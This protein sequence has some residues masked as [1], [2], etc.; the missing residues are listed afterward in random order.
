VAATAT[1]TLLVTDGEHGP[2]VT[3]FGAVRTAIADAVALLRSGGESGTGEESGTDEERGNSAPRRVAITVGEAPPDALEGTDA[4]AEAIDLL[5]RTEPGQLL[6]SPTARG[7]LGAHRYRLEARPDG[8]ALVEWR[9]DR[10]D[11]ALPAFLATGRTL[12]GRDGNLAQA[13]QVVERGRGPR[14]I[15]LRGEPG[16][17]KTALAGV[18]AGLARDRGYAV[19]AGRCTE[20][21][22]VPYQPVVDACRHLVDAMSVEMLEER[23]GPSARLLPIV[24]PRL[25]I[26]PEATSPDARGLLHR[27]LGDL[28]VDLLGRQP[29]LLVVDDVQWAR[30]R[31]IELLADAW[32]AATDGGSDGDR[33][34]L[35]TQRTGDAADTTAEAIERLADDV[36]AE[37]VD[38][39]ALG[40]DDIA[41]LIALHDADL[42]GNADTVREIQVRSGGNPFFAEELTFHFRDATGSAPVPD[43]LREVVLQRVEDLAPSATS[44]LSM[45]A[46]VGARFSPA[47][48]AAATGEPIE[49]VTD[50][51]DAAVRR[52]LLVADADQ[53]DFKHALARDALYV[54]MTRAR[55]RRLHQRLAAALG[56]TN[57]ELV[58]I[59]RALGATVDT[60]DAVGT[61]A[62]AVAEATQPMWV[63]DMRPLLGRSLSALDLDPHPRHDRA[64]LFLQFAHFA[65]FAGDMADAAKYCEQ[66]AYEAR[67]VGDVGLF[68]LSVK[69]WGLAWPDDVSERVVPLAEEALRDA[70]DNDAAVADACVFLATHYSWLGNDVRRAAELCE[71]AYDAAV[72]LDED[73]RRAG[74]LIVWV[75]ALS[76]TA[77]LDK[78]RQF[79]REYIDI[80]QRDGETPTGVAFGYQAITELAA[81]DRDGFEAK[82][83][84]AARIGA[85][86]TWWQIDLITSQ[87]EG[88]RALLDGDLARVMT[89]VTASMGEPTHGTVNPVMALGGLAWRELGRTADLVP[90]ISA[91]ASDHS[92]AKL[93]T[94][95][96][97]LAHAEL[98]NVE[99]ANALL[100]EVGIDDYAELYKNISTGTTLA[101]VAEACW[102]LGD[103]ERARQLRRHLEPYTGQIIVVPIASGAIGAADYFL[104][105]LAATCGETDAAIGLLEAGLALS[106]QI[107][108][109]VLAG[110][111]AVGLATVLRDVDPTRA[112]A[113]VDEA[114]ATAERLGLARLATE[115]A[116]VFGDT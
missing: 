8:T 3:V 52:G 37:V 65:Y 51:L 5:A 103:A 29:T 97:A 63:R 100:D 112:G 83:A 116:A 46:A 102:R 64:E 54:S 91:I 40:S 71:L 96:L 15:V 2:A 114:Q 104:G 12:V 31:T 87:L 68:A 59:Q 48:L 58:A 57:I 76:G 113:L 82:A 1:L 89:V 95:M 4:L 43:S 108:S 75:Q 80:H 66:A 30:P 34:L 72:R 27:A 26:A 101:F 62:L 85:A 21:L 41:A 61:S 36:G 84:E 28:L 78:R 69:D 109:P 56:E 42:G 111:A 53:H 49:T 106:R 13:Q 55:Q 24:F 33:V 60:L 98:G 10:S 50:I 88:C 14:V 11:A 70:A 22:A 16:I 81:G 18:I 90:M 38:L 25:G 7:V 79:I 115:A 107:R 93:V 73:I 9:P 86:E 47:L 92:T 19:L 20:D 110:H 99:Q 77:Q 44:V 39:H 17:G 94:P 45:A 35:L 6:L 74:A 32:K 105:L 23:L 67:R